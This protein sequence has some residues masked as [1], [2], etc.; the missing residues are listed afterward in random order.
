MTKKRKKRTL[1]THDTLHTL[2]CAAKN[3]SD[4]Q[5]KTRICAL[6]A[7]KMNPSKT[8]IAKQFLI[9]RK[10]LYAWIAAYNTGGINALKMS[11][12]G[13]PEGNPVWD[14]DIFTKLVEE[15]T[16]SNQCWSAPL[17][18]EWIKKQYKQDIPES[19]VY[20]HLKRLKFSYTSV[21]PHPYKGDKKAQ[22]VF[23]K[24]DS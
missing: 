22:D 11:T 23:K 14:T 21:R 10:T 7:L 9:D 3:V 2:E 16:K 18:Q 19:T 4:P 13:R 24:K 17:M 5:Q 15:V 1:C 8:T 6:I 12:G 20:Y